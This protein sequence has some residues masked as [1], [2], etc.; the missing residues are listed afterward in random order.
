M[1]HTFTDKTWAF[2][3]RMMCKEL[4]CSD[5]AVMLSSALSEDFCNRYNMQHIIAEDYILLCKV[6]PITQ[7]RWSRILSRS[8]G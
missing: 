8:S 6:M 4:H 2:D 3:T 1:S 5:E 7:M